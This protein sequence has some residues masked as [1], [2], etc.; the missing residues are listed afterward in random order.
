MKGST[1]KCF[2]FLYWELQ[3]NIKQCY[4]PLVDKGEYYGKIFKEDYD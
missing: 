3:R 4:N 1:D 2:L